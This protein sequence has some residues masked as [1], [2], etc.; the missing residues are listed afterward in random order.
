MLGDLHHL[1]VVTEGLVEL[2]HREFG[3]VPR[4]DALVAEHAADLE[5]PLHAADDEPLQVQLERDAQVELHVEGVVVRGER[6]GVRAARLHVKHR[7]LHLDVAA[8]RESAAEAG[9]GGV[10]HLEHAAGLLVHDEVRV[11]L[12]VAGVGVGDSVPLVG[13]GTDRLGEQFARRDLHREFPLAG[14]HDGAAHPHPV[15]EVQGV[16]RVEGGVADDPLRDEQLDGPGAVLESD[17]DELSLVATEHHTARDRDLGVR[18][19]PWF[20]VRV[21]G[22]DLPERV[23]PV[24]AVGVRVRPLPAHLIDPGEPSGLLGL[25]SAAR[26]S[27]VVLTHRNATVVGA[28]RPG[29]SGCATTVSA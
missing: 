14:G 2:H 25:E 11:A 26:L 28:D 29:E 6:P 7:G 22:A 9:D 3:V 13:E 24:E 20:Q 8:V 4:G 17:E 27:L 1:G 19:R 10:A 23:G 21:R 18:L 16:D 12:A 15:A 5:D